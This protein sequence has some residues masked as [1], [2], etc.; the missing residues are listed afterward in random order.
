MCIKDKLI[1][2]FD[3]F[4][5]VCR[6]EDISSFDVLPT[7]YPPIYGVYHVMMAPGWQ[8]LVTKQMK[9]LRESGLLDATEQLFVS[10]IVAQEG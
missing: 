1:T 7:S 4:F 6:R 2:L 9:N 10:V 3:S 8:T 5:R